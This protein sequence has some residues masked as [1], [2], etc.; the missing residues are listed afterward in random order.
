MLNLHSDMEIPV[1]TC[2]I[3]VAKYGGLTLLGRSHSYFY[4]MLNYT[5]S[6]GRRVCFAVLPHCLCYV[7]IIVQIAI[8][9]IEELQV[10][11]S[12][13]DEC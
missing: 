6:A 11:I 1:D 13:G 9:G 12:F 8:A 4:C 10:F 2:S 5:Y 7:V 3:Q